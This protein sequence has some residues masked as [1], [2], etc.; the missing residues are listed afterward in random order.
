[1]INVTVEDDG[2]GIPHSVRPWLFEPD[3]ETGRA[4]GVGLRLVHDIVAAHGGGMVIKSSSE[5][6]ERGTAVTLWLPVR[7]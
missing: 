4:A 5:P 7:S 1:M 2:L 6:R 3:P